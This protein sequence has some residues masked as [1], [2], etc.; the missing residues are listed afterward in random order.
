M[1]RIRSVG[2]LSCAKIFGITYA[3]VGLLFTPFAV[4]GGLAAMIS[5]QSHGAISS[6]GS[7]FWVCWRLFSTARWG[8]IR[9]ALGLDIQPYSWLGRRHRN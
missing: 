9:C 7:S 2:V 5:E 8:S 1:Q 4:L 6:A 3:C